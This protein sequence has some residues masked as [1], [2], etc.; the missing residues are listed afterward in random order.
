[1]VIAS[2]I[3]KIDTED[4]KTDVPI[5]IFLPVNVD[6]HWQCEYEIGWPTGLRRS[7][8]YGVDPVQSLHLALQ[9]IGAEIYTSDAHRSGKLVWLERGDGYGFPVPAGI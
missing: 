3:F 2:R 7:K 8:A 1:M 4:G 5:R 6:D 9:K